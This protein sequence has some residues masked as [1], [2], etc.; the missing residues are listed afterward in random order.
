V[1]ERG[2]ETVRRVSA[3][4]GSSGPRLSCC[5]IACNEERNIRRCLESV[6][7]ADE[8]VVVVDSRSSDATEE[9]ARELGARVIEH[10]YQ[11]NIEQKNFALSQ[12]KRDWILS[13]DADEVITEPL[14]REISSVLAAPPTHIDGYQINR[15]TYHLGR[16]IRHGDFYPDWQLRLI[17]RGAGDWSGVNPHGRIQLRGTVRRLLGECEHY[18]Y[19]DLAAQIDRIQDF[20][21]I[22]ARAS[23]AEGLPARIRDMVLRPPARFFRAYLLKQG[24]RDGVPGL[25]IA[26][27]TAFHVFLKYAKLWELDRVHPRED[28]ARNPG[29]AR[30]AS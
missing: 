1:S 25:V 28:T 5:I 18:S 15:V 12:A 16:W 14:A 17:R 30:G 6:S 7:F 2:R 11:G 27:A 10:P 29:K 21:R 24:F 19:R 20:S 4:S 23:H 26:A 13:L 22:Q 8:C 3:D 9:I